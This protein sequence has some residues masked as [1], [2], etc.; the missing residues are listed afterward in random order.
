MTTPIPTYPFD[1]TG[2]AP[3][4]KIVGETQIL[5]APD[6]RNY[7]FIIPSATPFFR[8][9]LVITHYPSNRVLVEGVDY[10]C[11]HQFYDASKACA[12][13]IYGSI[14]F[15]DKSLTGVAAMDYQ[16]LGGDWTLD[17][18]RIQELLSNEL[19]NP[20]TTTWDEI[21]DLPYQFPVIDHQWDLVDMVGASQV[22]G[23]LDDI[24]EA[25]EVAA[26]G[27]TD[28][29][30]NNYDN[31]H[32]V[33]KTQVGL[34][35]VENYGIADNASAVA[36]T[37]N[38]LYMTPLRVREAL[39]SQVGNA[40]VA[41]TNDLNNPHQVT[42]AQ[43]GLDKVENYGI[44][45]GAE[46]ASGVRNDVYLTPA[47]LNTAMQQRVDAVI[48][49]HINSQANPHGVTK[50]QVGLGNV[51]NYAMASSTMAQAGAD[52]AS[53]MSPL[54]VREALETMFGNTFN[55]H[56]NSQTNP[57]GVTKE[58]V[59][60]GEVQNLPLATDQAAMAGQDDSGYMTPRLTAIL[61]ATL[62]G[63]G[64]GT[65]DA[66]HALRTDNPHAVTA[67]QTGAYS[68]G[69]TDQLLLGKLGTTAT[70]ANAA[71]LQGLSYTDIIN[72]AKAR[73]ELPPVNPTGG[74]YEGFTW[75]P[76]GAYTPPAVIDPLNPPADMVF[77]YTGGDRRDSTNTPI[78]LVKINVYP[79]AH[80]SVEQMAGDPAEID[81]G[82]VR[83]DETQ[84]LSIYS[85]NPPRR[86][87]VS[88]LALS[89]PSNGI[90]IA[91]APLDSAPPDVV[92]AQEFSYAAAATNTDA[93]PGD[94]TYGRNPHL[95]EDSD[96]DTAVV[97]I[98]VVDTAGDL[99]A[100]QIDQT[101]L[102]EEFHDYVPMSTYGN[103]TRNA[104]VE[105]L[106]GW[107]WHDEDSAIVHNAVGQSLV[108]L[109][110]TNRYT[111]YVFE[112]KLDSTDSADMAMGVCAAFRRLDGKDHGIYVLRTPGGLV[113][114]SEAGN[115]PGGNIYKLLSVGYNLLQSDA[116][117][118]GSTNDGLIWGDGTL[119]ADRGVVGPY[120]SAGNG[121]S[122][123]MG[124]KIRI[125]RA[126]DLLSIEVGQLGSEDYVGGVTVTI[127]LTSRPELAVFRAP[128]AV[129]LVKYKQG[130]SAFQILAMPDYYRPYVEYAVNAVKQN[131]STIHRWNGEAWVSQSMRLDQSFIKPGRTL[132]SPLNN[133][134]FRS[135]RSGAIKPMYFEAF[136][137]EDVTVLTP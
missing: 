120:T 118:L 6:W 43:V 99:V 77:F 95:D 135:T 103:Q 137:R 35:N 94:L 9:S 84:V 22:V 16:T 19:A 133:R 69:E 114:S 117:D 10:V 128:T 48:G 110:Q 115:E 3:T 34:A 32:Q 92:M 134:L 31:P 119:D 25:I 83:D 40:F 67:A 72:Q 125:E 136:T 102:Y 30:V 127:D 4:N 131:V 60:L 112:V 37:S 17:E 91:Q 65:G 5:A 74:L 82:Y 101:P 42:K 38:T 49:P 36:G 12:R 89:D 63:G 55:T 79:T 47:A 23:K 26:S 51:P 59:G 71:R 85:K 121:W 29:H 11:T 75:T 111:D 13:E 106:L 68:K 126:G 56:L 44:S 129:G 53:F 97:E 130:S 78:Y 76:I 104:V 93:V 105:D 8:D 98:N 2:A 108:G 58:Q 39:L 113:L 116:I 109:R 41:H 122:N 73:F 132:Y 62:G 90:G 70:A 64:G 52:N 20:R 124:C 123:Q 86:N 87:A 46:A 28:A 66:A 107:D 96:T 81:F 18:T 61:V 57:H 1:P 24:R 54:R 88:L 7:F 80:M 15:Y 45:T 33:T 14:T 21:V 50:T 27:A 100:A